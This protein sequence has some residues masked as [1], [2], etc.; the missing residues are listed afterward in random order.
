MREE[1]KLTLPDAIRKFSALPAQRMRLA[2]RGVLKEGMWADVVVFD[3]DTIR[4]LATFE[5]P[6]QLSEGMRFVLV[7][8]V[9][10]IDEG[11]MTNAA[12]GQGA[13]QV[14]QASGRVSGLAFLKQPVD[15]VGQPG[16]RGGS[17]TDHHASGK[18]CGCAP[19]GEFQNAN[20][21]AAS[22]PHA[23]AHTGDRGRRG[24]VLFSF[25][26]CYLFSLTSMQF[27]GPA[28]QRLPHTNLTGRLLRRLYIMK[29]KDGVTC[30]FGLA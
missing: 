16:S 15:P 12:A 6:N 22:S 10:V 27:G 30:R 29:S 19:C 20:G 13:A 11:K 8:G 5:N 26:H 18:P 17:E 24:L 3:P 7:N 14:G 1:K 2:D 4:D 23:G 25:S 9:P 28:L 21:G